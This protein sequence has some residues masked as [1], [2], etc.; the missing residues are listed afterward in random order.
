MIDNYLSEVKQNRKLCLHS[1]RQAMKIQRSS[2]GS[3][4]QGFYA[5]IRCTS[6]LQS[7]WWRGLQKDIEQ[8]LLSYDSLSFIKIQYGE[9]YDERQVAG[10][11]N[12]KQ[13]TG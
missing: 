7:R 4:L 2:E 11:K 8:A 3:W 5:G 6:E 10:G 1:A 12:G 9:I 13:K